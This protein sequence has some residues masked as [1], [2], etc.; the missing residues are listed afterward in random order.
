MEHAKKNQ[1]KFWRLK[2][3]MEIKISLDS[4]NRD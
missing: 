3:N 1:I 2:I 4:L